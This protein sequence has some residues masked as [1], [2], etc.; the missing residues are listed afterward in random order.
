MPVLPGSGA[1]TLI[2]LLVVVAIIAIL[3][4][5]TIAALGGI[6][7]RGARDRAKA[8]I[9]GIVNALERY[10]SQHDSYPPAVSGSNL[11]Y[12]AI[13]GFMPQS[14]AEAG[15]TNLSD[16]YGNTYL[17][18]FPGIRNMATFDVWSPGQDTSS[19]ATNDDIGN[20]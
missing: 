18:R 20:W 17:Y 14:T 3:A 7:Q 6:N 5:I 11:P 1:F 2:E 13:S 16:P 9:A 12:A 4:G 15:F 19:A 10:R 8:E